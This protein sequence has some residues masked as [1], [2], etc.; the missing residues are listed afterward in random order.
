MTINFHEVQLQ[1]AK[2]SVQ[3]LQ[4]QGVFFR[5]ILLVLGSVLSIAASLGSANESPLCIRLVFATAMVLLTVGTLACMATLLF[6]KEFAMREMKAYLHENISAFQQGRQARPVLVPKKRVQ[7][8]CEYVV[9]ISLP[10][11][12]IALCLYSVMSVLQ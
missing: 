2:M 9:Y 12:I 5:H 7:I 6:H 8:I 4:D 1:A 10:L 3:S 11:A